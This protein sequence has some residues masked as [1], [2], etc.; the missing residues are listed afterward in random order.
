MKAITLIQPWATLIA[1]GEKRIETRSWPTNYRGP[2][3]I[4][5]GKKTPED[6]G[7]DAF[8]AALSRAGLTLEDLPRGAV[9]ATANLIDCVRF[10]GITGRLAREHCAITN[11]RTVVK[12]SVGPNEWLYGDFSEGRYGFVLDDV[13]PLPDPI[14]ARGYQGLW[15][16][17]G[18][19]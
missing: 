8:Y 5:A 19:S 9:V 11:T 7:D 3:A 13:T 12:Y 16:W 15:D 10:S 18:A 17:D 2:I 6:L 14:P 1:L 4:H